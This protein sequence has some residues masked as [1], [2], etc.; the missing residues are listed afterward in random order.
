M[1]I[2]FQTTLNSHFFPFR[3][4]FP[5]TKQ[6]AQ[7]CL[8]VAVP[9][10]GFGFAD[11]AWLGIEI[12]K[13]T[14][15]N[16]GCIVCTYLYIIFMYIYIYI[17]IS[18]SIS[19]NYISIYIYIYNILSISMIFNCP[20]IYFVSPLV[21]SFHRPRIMIVCGDFIDAQFG[22]MFGLTTM[23]S[24]G[25]TATKQK[26]PGGR[27]KDLENLWKYRISWDFHGISFIGLLTSSMVCVV[28]NLY[29]KILSKIYRCGWNSHYL[30]IDHFPRET[31]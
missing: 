9:F 2:P 12:S 21:R 19:R 30:Y 22:V 6:L 16:Q 24:A 28:S 8:F 13:L 14:S 3:W 5:G 1:K 15:A 26:P 10:F 29:P 20:D 25:A 23:A 31:M 18:I 7:L 4:L 17:R 11:N 27:G